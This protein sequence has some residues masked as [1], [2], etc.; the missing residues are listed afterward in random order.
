MKK[1]HSHIFVR[2]VA[3]VAHI[4]IIGIFDKDK[5]VLVRK[6]GW[7]VRQKNQRF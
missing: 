5:G 4:Q 2:F 6:I 3:V 7:G 1:N